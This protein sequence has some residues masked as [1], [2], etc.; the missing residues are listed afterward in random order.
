M[1]GNK[2]NKENNMLPV[3]MGEDQGIKELKLCCRQAKKHL[4]LAGP[5]LSQKD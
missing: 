2:K 1:C 5:A 3:L 4:N